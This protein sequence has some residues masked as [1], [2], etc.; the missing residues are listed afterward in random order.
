MLVLLEYTNGVDV[1]LLLLLLL[2]VLARVLT[3]AALL[4]HWMPRTKCAPSSFC[5]RFI[6][7]EVEEVE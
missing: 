4:R 1:L 6:K 7:F 5:F 3:L 2:L